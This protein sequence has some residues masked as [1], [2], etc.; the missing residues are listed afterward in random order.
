MPAGRERE[1]DDRVKR[2]ISD[3]T[4]EPGERYGITYRRSGYDP[5]PC[6]VQNGTLSRTIEISTSEGKLNLAIPSQ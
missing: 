5:N 4:L 6:G 3:I 2:K 1:W